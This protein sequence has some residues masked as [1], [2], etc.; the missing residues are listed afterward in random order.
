MTSGLALRETNSGFDPVSR[1]LFLERDQAAFAERARLDATPGTQWQYSTGNT[2]LLGRIIRDAVG[3]DAEAVVRFARDELFAPLGMST[4]L[5]EYDAT[6]VPIAMYASA[7]DWARFGQLF[8]SDGVVRGRRIL[9]AHWVVY[10]T[11]P[12]LGL[13]YGAGWWLGGPRWRPDWQ[14]PADAYYAAGHLHQKILVIPSAQLV[15]ARFGVTHAADDGLGTI[16][17]EVLAAL[18]A[19]PQAPPTH[20]R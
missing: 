17:T 9:P 6:G 16:A 1:M 13:G 12:T 14:L 20:A 5:L 3:G 19:S 4:A 18:A 2:V 10:S 8:A 15:I 11:T 7:R